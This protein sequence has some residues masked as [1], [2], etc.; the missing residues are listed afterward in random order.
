MG[1]P[2]DIGSA[3]PLASIVVPIYNEAGILR[4]NTERLRGYLSDRLPSHEIVLCENGSVDG[5]AEIVRDLSEEFDNVRFLVLPEPCLADALKAGFRAAKA[6]KVVYFP[7]D[8]S[9][10]LGFIPRSVRLLDVFDVVVGSKRLTSELDR[11][12]FVRRAVSRAFHGI[13]RGFYGVDFTD[14]TCVKAYRKSKIMELMDRFPTSSRIYETELL[15]EASREGLDIVEVPVGVEEH[16]PS[17]V[18]LGSKIRRKLEDLLTARLDLISLF[19]G[20]PMFVGGLLSILTLT[21]GKVKS[22]TTSGFINP[23]SFLISML[24]VISGFQ[25]LTFGLLTNLIMQ[26]RKQVSKAG[27]G[28]E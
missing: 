1:R 13:V 3:E 24:L 16:R 28:R 5:T 19:V 4:I 8:L 12:P 11:R 25:I 7:I 26:I 20:T 9:A 10:D 2:Q 17:R 23:Y 27:N 22:G 21:V 18:V 14:T 6:D 15:V